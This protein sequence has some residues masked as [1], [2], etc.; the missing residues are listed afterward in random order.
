MSWL[1]A[2]QVLWLTQPDADMFLHIAAERHTD[3]L[4]CGS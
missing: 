3:L 4:L 1:P 2:G